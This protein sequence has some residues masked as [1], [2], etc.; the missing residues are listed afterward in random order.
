MYIV[1]IVLVVVGVM[2]IIGTLIWILLDNNKKNKQRQNTINIMKGQQYP[3]NI[4]NNNGPYYISNIPPVVTQ[5]G[6]KEEFPF[7]DGLNNN[8]PIQNIN[9]KQSTN[10]NIN[11]SINPDIY[12]SV[13]TEDL[14]TESLFNSDVN[15]ESLVYTD[16]NSE[17]LVYDMQN[18]T[19]SIDF[20]SENKKVNLRKQEVNT[21]DKKINIEKESINI[22]MQE[23]QI[24]NNGNRLLICP[25]CQQSVKE[26]DKFCNKCGQ[27]LV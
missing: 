7:I 22:G 26:G 19:D 18:Y 23:R 1:G 27:R 3:Q 2:G 5:D 17:N 20:E 25:K 9:K 11:S 24:N 14:M 13:S 21:E 10:Q 8:Y 16:G 12:Q 15:T 4:P 6:P